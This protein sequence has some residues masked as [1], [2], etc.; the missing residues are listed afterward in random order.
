MSNNWWC[1][2]LIP[3]L[4]ICIHD[5]LCY[6]TVKSDTGQHSQFLRCF[7][8]HVVWVSSGFSSWR[9][10]YWIPARGKYPRAAI[11]PPDLHEENARPSQ[12]TLLDWVFVKEGTWRNPENKWEEYK[13]G[14]CKLF[15][16]AEFVRLG[17]S[18]LWKCN[19]WNFRNWEIR[20]FPTRSSFCLLRQKVML[21][22]GGQT[23]QHALLVS[24][25][26]TSIF[27]SDYFVFQ[28]PSF[29][30]PQ[31][32]NQLCGMQNK[33]CLASVTIQTSLLV[34][35]KVNQQILRR[36][37]C[38]QRLCRLTSTLSVSVMDTS[39]FQFIQHSPKWRPIQFSENVSITYLY[40]GMSKN[41][42]LLRNLYLMRNQLIKAVFDRYHFFEV[43]GLW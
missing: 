24:D 5:N 10:R 12:I 43:S 34:F 2:Q 19:A 20:V 36:Q 35:V 21:R 23:A 39:A 29:P 27:S 3:I 15:Y 32:S 42:V 16:S 30:G 28:L 37:C 38:L 4:T 31:M 13:N 9:S 41:L 26:L 6:L 11:Q 18:Y 1:E 7:Y 25:N 33:G 8:W 22:T 40:C 14:E 17:I